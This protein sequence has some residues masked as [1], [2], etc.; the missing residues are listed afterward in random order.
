MLNAYRER[1]AQF[2][3]VYLGKALALRDELIKRYIQIG[4]V[5]PKSQNGVI[6]FDYQSLAG[7]DPIGEAATYLETLARELPDK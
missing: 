2:K 5:P 3:Q 4:V 1:E 7:P 6:A